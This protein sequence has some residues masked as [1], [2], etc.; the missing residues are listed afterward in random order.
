M[1]RL[2]ETIAGIALIIG[3]VAFCAYCIRTGAERKAAIDRLIEGDTVRVVVYD[4]VR[5]V[6]PEPVA[7]TQLTPKV[8]RL[9]VVTSGANKIAQ[10]YNNL[11]A[12]VT[13]DAKRAA[14]AASEGVINAPPALPAWVYTDSADV[15]V[16]VERKVYTGDSWRAVVSGAFVSLDTMEVYN[17]REV[18]TIRQPPD[19]PK[20]WSLGVGVGYGM[21]PHGMQ[22]FVGVTLSY[23][24]LRF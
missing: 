9:P 12:R 16:P 18:V 13:S 24:L 11:S 6:A 23:A 20:R 10:D 7:T 3:I 15:A 19:K 2:I 1:K 8:A 21:T 14:G 17:R 22:P 4:T 5:V